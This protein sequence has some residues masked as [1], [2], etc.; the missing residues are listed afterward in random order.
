MQVVP[1]RPSEAE[2]DE[3]TRDYRTELLAHC[4]R[5]TGS[6]HEA[7]D[8][9]QETYL[10]AWR[11]FDAFEGRSSV[12]TYLYRIATN[13][14]LTALRRRSRRVMPSA[15]ATVGS[16]GGEVRW[17]EPM[18]DTLLATLASDPAAAAEARTGVR[19]AFIAALQHLSPIRRAVLI[20]RD[21][22]D[23]SAAET[24]DVL[25]M[26]PA[27]VNSALP[28]ARAQ[29]AHAAPAADTI[30][31]PPEPRRREILDQ[32]VRAF[33][34]ADIGALAAL[35]RADIT[36]EMPPLPHWFAGAEAVTGFFASEVL[37]VPG[38]FTM[39]PTRANG[40]PAFL[41]Y[42]RDDAYHRDGAYHRPHAVHVLGLGATGIARI[43]VFLAP[44]A[45]APF[46][47]DT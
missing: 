40:Q 19:L 33:E 35:M 26:T 8:L 12:R 27:S 45:T 46:T 44:A 14:C 24:A 17:L 21:V 47:R 10:R 5:M 2:F 15:V 34:T 36:L 16:A 25:D 28:R 6:V 1:T 7:E 42:H 23:L 11:S 32:Y 38:Q 29:I 18:P 41:A 20:L 22:L 30:G 37:G 9:V 3:L 31:E 13:A 39:R 43:T 4:Y